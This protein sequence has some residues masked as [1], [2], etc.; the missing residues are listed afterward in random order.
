MNIHKKCPS[1]AAA[2]RGDGAV[3]DRGR[4]FQSPCGARLWRVAKIVARWVERYKVEGRAGTVDRS[5][6]PAH[7]PQAPL[8]RS[9]NASWRCGGY[10]GPASTSPMRSA[11]RPLPA[12]GVLKRA[13][14]RG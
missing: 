10:V 8:R 7:T 4:F 11:A 14:C 6:R 5:S 9:P 1:H 13:D 3:G 2:S 12:V